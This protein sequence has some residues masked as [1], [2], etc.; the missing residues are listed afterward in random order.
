MRELLWFFCKIK[1]TCGILGSQRSGLACKLRVAA[2][3]FLG[4]N[5]YSNWNF[6]CACIASSCFGVPVHH[7]NFWYIASELLSAGGAQDLWYLL[8][9][10]SLSSSSLLLL[11]VCCGFQNCEENS[12]R[13]VVCRVQRPT[14]PVAVWDIQVA[15]LTDELLYSQIPSIYHILVQ[16]CMMTLGIDDTI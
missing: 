11:L 15:T 2:H 8:C 9:P 12:C 16:S 1:Q 7:T 13:A 6:A 14:L 4:P 3:S 5:M 10:F